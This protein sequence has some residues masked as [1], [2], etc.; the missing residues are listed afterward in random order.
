MKT[1]KLLLSL[2]LFLWVGLSML[3]SPSAYAA[4]DFE[5]IC[6]SEQTFWGKIQ[7]AWDDINSER[8][9]MSFLATLVTNGL[10]SFGT[11]MKLGTATKCIT[12]MDEE[13]DLGAGQLP[14]A[15]EL[16]ENQRTQCASLVNSYVSDT[17]AAA[18][19][20]GQAYGSLAS[21]ANATGV[22]AQQPIPVNMAYYIDRQTENVPFVNKAFAQ[23][24]GSD[25]AEYS[26]PLLPMTF[27]LWR[28]VRNLSYAL[29]AII[30]VIIGV[31]IMTRKKI[32]PQTMVSV[33]YAIPKIIIALILITFSYP[34]GATIASV[35]WALRGSA[36]AI[37]YDLGG[38]RDLAIWPL[39]SGSSIV[40]GLIIALVVGLA[41]GGVGL[42][43][44]LLSAAGFI[45]ALVIY[46][47]I[48]VK[49]LIIYLQIVT[50][51]ITSPLTFAWSA[52][53][54]NES[55]VTD[56]FKSVFV[57]VGALLGMKAVIT[58]THLVAILLS[59]ETFTS[60][61]SDG[62]NLGNAG[63]LALTAI[64]LPFI[65]QF[66]FLFGYYQAWQLPKKLDGVF[67]NPKGKR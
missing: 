9:T 64:I 46:I 38:F 34:I 28:I 40:G 66:I 15:C 48:H 45:L 42:V 19:T 29:M 7:N 16:T 41:T 58:M 43:T 23:F 61:L 14:A 25:A 17:D 35:A 52:V 3:F 55:K 13:F 51:T 67:L 39:V 8:T 10:F 21:I 24:G 50:Q 5:N 32:N 20:S 11:N 59:V 4:I 30:M 6:E 53:P 31:M 63:Q 47:A 12:Y 18:S 27:S 56:W 60:I 37:V 1:K 36:S 62:T 33:Q 57:K 2:T 65:I 49:I 44:M 26:G 54:G 22:A